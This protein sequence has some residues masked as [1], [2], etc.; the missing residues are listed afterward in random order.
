MGAVLPAASAGSTFNCKGDK[1]K[2]DRHGRTTAPVVVQRYAAVLD[3]IW[4]YP[5]KPL[6]TLIVTGEVVGDDYSFLL[7]T[8]SSVCPIFSLIWHHK[9]SGYRWV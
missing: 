7:D 1:I 4:R 9:D 3:M 8:V 2:L 6:A 5:K